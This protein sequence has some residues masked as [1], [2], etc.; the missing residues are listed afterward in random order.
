MY[1]DITDYNA[2]VENNVSGMRV[3][4]AFNNEDH[5]INRFQRN[6]Y[7]FFLTKCITYKIMARNS[8][9]RHILMKLASIFIL[10]CGTWFLIKGE[11]GN[12]KFMSFIYYL[13][14]FLNLSKK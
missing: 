12:G 3:V 7:K 11:M 13:I 9:I 5:E 6:N 14:Y 8:S 1:E 2:R 4:Q 10:L